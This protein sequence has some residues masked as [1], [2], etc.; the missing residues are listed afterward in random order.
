[1]RDH[2]VFLGLAAGALA[3]DAFRANA[4]G[5]AELATDHIIYNTVTGNLFFDAVRPVPGTRRPSIYLG[6]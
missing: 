1:M 4:A 2:A 5:Q 6:R 3:A